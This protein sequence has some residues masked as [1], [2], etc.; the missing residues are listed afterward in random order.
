MKNINNNSSGGVGTPH[1][2]N[3]TCDFPAA[4]NLALC[5]TC[6]QLQSMSSDPAEGAREDEFEGE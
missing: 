5:D 4:H 1:C 2:A 3:E 6:S